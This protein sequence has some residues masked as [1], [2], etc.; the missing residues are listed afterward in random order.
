MDRRK[1]LKT[2]A[3]STAGAL[4]VPAA[5][6]A[7]ATPEQV[8]EYNLPIKIVKGPYKMPPEM[9]YQRGV[10]RGM[11]FNFQINVSKYFPDAQRT[12]GVYVPAQYKAD[13][14]ACVMVM[15]DGLMGSALFDNFIHQNV[16]PVT[17]GIGLA[18]G[19]T[20]SRHPP[21][22]P[23]WNRSFE[24]DSLTNVL[25]EFVIHEL[26]PAMQ[27]R[28]TPDGR[29]IRLSDDPSDRAIMG[30]S[31]G[32]IGA[33]TVAWQRP[34]AF[35]RVFTSSATLVGMRGG[36]RYPMLV[37]KTE[38]KPLR[39]FMLD[40]QRDEWWGGPEFGDWWLSNVEMERSLFYAGYQVNHLWGE[41]GH[42][43]GPGGTFFPMALRW[44]WK[45]WHKPIKAGVPGN[46]VI[47]RLV[48][49][50]KPWQAVFSEKH[51]ETKLKYPRSIYV[52][53]PVVDDNSTVGQLACDQHGNVF[54]QNPSNGNICRFTGNGTSSLFAKVQPGNNGLAFGP[55]GRMYIAETATSRLLVCGPSG[56]TKVL[57]D[58]IAG[59]SLTVSGEGHIY[60]T[61]AR[62]SPS[63][64]GK[65]WLIRPNGG[66]QIVAEG[67]NDPSGI[68]L[69]P[70]GLWLCVAE[71]G[72]HHAWSYRV[73][74]DGAL[75]YGEPFYWFHVPD[76]ANDS[77]IGQVCWDTNGWGYAATRLGVQV[78]T[79]SGGEGGLVYA[80]L[81]VNE[82]QIEGIC[83]GDKDFKTLYV[84]TGSEIYRR[85]T[86]ALG[87]PQWKISAT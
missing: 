33:F 31:T 44:L 34:D 39:V 24:F 48:Q 62:S 25:A 17:I 63:Y 26:L 56:Q 29:A 2:A 43:G 37:R 22:D 87:V 1:F 65:V 8:A 16:M 57:A 45:D 64:S 14:P 79:T 76:A 30:G 27:K 72:G 18:P 10:P 20:P 49:P 84:S 9:Q 15:L 7:S 46:V 51:A 4:A 81:P 74:P 68:G 40:G 11:V 13:K 50:G 75:Q 47:R 12:I 52:A 6:L 70:D 28:K 55:D 38:P 82:K 58:T 59:R 53:G 67:L 36:D 5:V 41:W 19:V 80:I 23:R 69:T 60:V 83:F 32:A 85:P 21:A 61:E 78:F 54:S 42:C 86:K 3:I 73:Q 35:R 66:K 77:G 71:H